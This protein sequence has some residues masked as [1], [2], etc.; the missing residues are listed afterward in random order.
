MTL[1]RLKNKA[2]GRISAEAVRLLVRA[3]CPEISLRDLKAAFR[4]DHTDDVLAEI[5]DAV[6]DAVEVSWKKPRRWPLTAFGVPKVP[7][8][9]WEGPFWGSIAVLN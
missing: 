9:A 7:S 1:A 2:G 3:R 8:S 4:N 6:T 5:A